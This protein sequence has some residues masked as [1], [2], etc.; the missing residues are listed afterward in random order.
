MKTRALSK[1]DRKNQILMAFA[2]NIQAGGIG[3]LTSVDVA[4]KIG[5]VPSKHVRDFLKELVIEGLLE[6]IKEPMS[7]AVGCRWIY[8]PTLA[9]D[10]R[11][12]HPK[13]E[14]RTIAIKTHKNGQLALFSEVF[15]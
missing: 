15:S 12:G 13:R 9:F 3:E 14:P 6:S 11:T 8:R 1:D 7:G 5:L 4:H 2:V 10:A